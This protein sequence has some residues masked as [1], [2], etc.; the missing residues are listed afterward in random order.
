MLQRY[1]EFRLAS[2][3]ISTIR[4]GVSPGHE[5]VHA[6]RALSRPQEQ[7]LQWGWLRA[8]RD[9]VPRESLELLRLV[10][11]ETGYAPDLFTSAASWDLTPEDEIERLRQAPLE[12]ISV[13]LHKRAVRS[14]GIARAA[15]ERMAAD[16]ARIRVMIVRHVEA[17]WEAALA[18]YWAQ[19]ERILHADIG[20]RVRRMTAE[21]LAG[22]AAD[23]G[24]GVEWS[25]DT[26]RV[27]MERHEE[28]VDCQG[29]GLVLVP[30]FFG[31]H[32]AVLTEP[33]AQPT[34]F[35]PALGVS[36]VWHRADSTDALAGLLGESRAAVL[37]AVGESLSTTETAGEAGIAAS[38]AS[39][40]LD[41]LRAAG[42]IASRRAGRRVLHARTPLGDALVHRV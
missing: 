40:H 7:P 14:A 17:L 11:G 23:L 32:C 24:E 10:V 27:R 9:D 39:H 20:S 28:I 29:Q 15:L 2:K 26:V 25:A 18:P 12:P 3:D 6:V 41:A 21:G 38:T 8:V 30:S 4:F 5:I 36:E 37:V 1:V 35:Y 22:M 13:D 19:I 42:L 33:P 34:L 16:P 31:R